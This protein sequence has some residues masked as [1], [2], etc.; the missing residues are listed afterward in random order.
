MGNTRIGKYWKDISKEARQKSLKKV[1]IWGR[2]ATAVISGLAG[3]AVSYFGGGNVL[4]SIYTALIIISV[5]GAIWLV[6]FIVH[7][8][9]EPVLIHDDKD[10]QINKLQAEITE[11]KNAVDAYERKAVAESITLGNGTWARGKSIK[12]SNGEKRQSFDGR[13]CVTT[14]PE[15]NKHGHFWG[16]TGD[17]NVVSCHVPPTDSEEVRIIDIGDADTPSIEKDG[18]NRINFEKSGEYTIITLLEGNFL[19]PE[20]PIYPIRSKWKFIVD[21]ENRVFDLVLVK[22]RLE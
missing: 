5:W 21:R 10:T 22:E 3:G 9:R 6:G 2:I 1:G 14:I 19:N 16:R 12:I 4:N 18:M 7:L 20:T 8:V 13:L 11:L 15:L 17:M